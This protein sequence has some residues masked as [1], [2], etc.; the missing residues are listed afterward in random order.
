MIKY[1]RAAPISYQTGI[2]VEEKSD[3][4]SDPCFM[5]ATGG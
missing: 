2:I 3:T 5:F 1:K 4:Y